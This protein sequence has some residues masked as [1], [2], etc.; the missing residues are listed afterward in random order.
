MKAL[1]A[2][3]LSMA[4]TGC[5][6]ISYSPIEMDS[7]PPQAKSPALCLDGAPGVTVSAA[8]PEKG[9]KGPEA[10]LLLAKG[11]KCMFP[12]R[13]AE[14][15]TLAPLVTEP[16]QNYRITVPRNQVWYDSGRRNVAPAGEHGSPF[17]NLA[18]SLK[19]HRDAG[20]FALFAAN[21]V[22]DGASPGQF[23]DVSGDQDLVVSVPG[24]LAF[25]PKDAIA[26]L[27][28]DVFYSNN[29][30]Q[31]WVQIEHCAAVCQSNAADWP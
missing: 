17:M 31:V 28:R 8:K 14:Q 22:Y 21:I 11:A 26:P 7:P 13:A 6:A 20:W 23:I 2:L 15:L 3:L 27:L 12:V 4:L 5:V 29:S 18:R 25:Y 30:G 24:Q 10:R 16:G 19:R 1:A 9:G